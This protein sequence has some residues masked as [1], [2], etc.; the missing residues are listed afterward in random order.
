MR[1]LSRV[2]HERRIMPENTAGLTEKLRAQDVDT[3]GYARQTPALAWQLL[4]N[5]CKIV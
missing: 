5:I 4:E 2:V 1:N 3:K